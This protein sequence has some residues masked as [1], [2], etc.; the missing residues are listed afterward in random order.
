M[1]VK[2]SGVPSYLNRSNKA[3]FDSWLLSELSSSQTVQKQ[4]ASVFLCDNLPDVTKN[5]TATPGNRA[6]N[7]S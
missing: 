4:N 6:K 3:G 5:R 1:K 7:M 2:L